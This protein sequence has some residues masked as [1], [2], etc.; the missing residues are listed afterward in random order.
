MCDD[1]EIQLAIC[2]FIFVSGGIWQ[3]QLHI[4]KE[5]LIASSLFQKKVLRKKVEKDVVR[6]PVFKY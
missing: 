2:L 4:N 1:W 6:Q 5:V 3:E